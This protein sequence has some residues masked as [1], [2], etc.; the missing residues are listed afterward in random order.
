MVSAFEFNGMLVVSSKVL[1]PEMCMAHKDLMRYARKANAK[2]QL[3]QLWRSIIGRESQDSLPFVFRVMNSDPYCLISIDGFALLIERMPDR[4]ARSLGAAAMDAF[5]DEPDDV[6][7]P[8]GDWQYDTMRVM[9]D[10][11]QKALDA[12]IEA[13]RTD[14]SLYRGFMRLRRR[15]LDLKDLFAGNGA[16]AG[17]GKHA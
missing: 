9:L 2:W 3:S 17:R 1:A 13:A 11:V 12:G 5:V 8:K 16:S 15:G 7:E 10:G 4:W 6:P 14:V